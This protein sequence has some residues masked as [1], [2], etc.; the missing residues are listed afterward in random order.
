MVMAYRTDYAN[1]RWATA[2]AIASLIL[3]NDHIWTFQM[4]MQ[5]VPGTGEIGVHGG[6]MS[7]ILTSY[8][9]NINIPQV[10]TPW[11]VIPDGIFLFRPEI[12]SSTFIMP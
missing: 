6:G 4:V 7:Y 2:P 5:G 9:S 1:K 10:T 8:H 11:E 3:E 12:L